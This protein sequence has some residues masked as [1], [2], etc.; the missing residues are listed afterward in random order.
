M[1]GN[2]LV[3]TASPRKVPTFGAD[4]RVDV[5]NCKESV[6]RGRLQDGTA[7][8][9]SEGGAAKRHRRPRT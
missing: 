3:V 8:W 1:G 9:N 4:S 7:G 6:A 5:V 2:A